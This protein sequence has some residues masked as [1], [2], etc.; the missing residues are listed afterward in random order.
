VALARTKTCR[1]TGA[2]EDQAASAPELNRGR[3]EQGKAELGRRNCE[4]E[5]YYDP[6][7]I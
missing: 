1:R 3:S 4:D 7:I 6:I 2:D 5:N